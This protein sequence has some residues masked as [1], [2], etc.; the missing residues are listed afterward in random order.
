MSTLSGEVHTQNQKLFQMVVY[1]FLPQH[2]LYL[3]PFPQIQGSFRP[4][5]G[6]ALVNGLCEGGQQLVLVQPELSDSNIVS[7][8]LLLLSLILTK[9]PH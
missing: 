3:R 5:L 1:V 2:F 8:T 4:T 7:D 9:K 6:V